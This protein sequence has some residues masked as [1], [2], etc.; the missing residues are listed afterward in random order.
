MTTNEIVQ[1]TINNGGCTYSPKTHTNLSGKPFYVVSMYPECEKIIP[2]DKF[3]SSH[4]L[5]YYC[6]HVELLRQ[7]SNSLGTWLNTDNDM[8]YLDIV[9]TVSDKDEA[10]TIAKDNNEIAIFDLL[11]M[12]EIRL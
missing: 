12:K 4:V 7:E 6:N 3:T 10:L 8:V 1:L 9:R 11:N 2:K 5:L